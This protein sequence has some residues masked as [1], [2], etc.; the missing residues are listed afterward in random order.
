M[1]SVLLGRQFE[2]PLKL[3]GEIF[4]IVVTDL[5]ANII[6][7]QRRV[8]QQLAGFLHAKLRDECCEIFAGNQLEDLP[9][10]VRGQIVLACDFIQCNR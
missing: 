10:I 1:L 2:A 4:D 3:L 8:L 7:F 6:M 9:K 5:S